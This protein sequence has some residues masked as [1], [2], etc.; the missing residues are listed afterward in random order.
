M[1]LY[2]LPG[3]FSIY[4]LGERLSV[5]AGFYPDEPL[6]SFPDIP[7]TEPTLLPINLS[8]SANPTIYVS[9]DTAYF[10]GAATRTIAVTSNG[11]PAPVTASVATTSC[12][13]C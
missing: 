7:Y 11:N 1:Y 12:G 10:Y 2:V 9:T 6:V 13:T 8:V 4:G 5:A 3:I